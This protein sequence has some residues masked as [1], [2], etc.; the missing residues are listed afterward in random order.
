MAA[1]GIFTGVNPGYKLF[2]LE[3]QLRLC[4]AKFLV[5]S[6]GCLEV[7]MD[8]A[9]EVCMG[10]DRIF[11][12]NHSEKD[13]PAGCKVKSW[14]TLIEHGE[15]EWEVIHDS[16]NE[17]ACYINSS[18]TSGLPKAVVV[19]HMYLQNQVEI[20][21]TR[22]LPYKVSTIRNDMTGLSLT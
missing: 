16:T 12:F 5:A 7:A 18:G 15:G 17:P 19:P 8:A 1:G 21:V 13:M 22:K 9:A 10:A 6:P 4:H 11:V 14:W 2:E 3:H 20:L